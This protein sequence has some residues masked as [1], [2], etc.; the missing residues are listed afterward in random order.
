[1]SASDQPIVTGRRSWDRLVVTEIGAGRTTLER[2]AHWNSGK[3]DTVTVVEVKDDDP[4]FDAL[5]SQVVDVMDTLAFV[6]DKIIKREPINVA[7]FLSECEHG[8]R[9]AMRSSR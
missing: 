1:M 4:D 3:G 8:L 7:H 9:E 5:V 6:R 2:L